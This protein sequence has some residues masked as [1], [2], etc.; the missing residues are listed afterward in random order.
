MRD[1]LRE[2]RVLSLMSFDFV[3]WAVALIAFAALRL[4][5]SVSSLDWLALVFLVGGCWLLQG[6][7]GWVLRLYHGRARVASLEEMLLLGWVAGTAGGITFAVNVLAYPDGLPRS[8]PLGGTFLALA[9]MGWGR[10]LWRRSKESALRVRSDHAEPALIFGAGDAGEQLVRS[11]LRDPQAAWAPVGLIDDDRWKQHLRID[12]VPVLGTRDS[13]AVAAEHTGARTLVIAVPSASAE[14]IRNV[15]GPARDAGLMVK[16]LPSLSE[17]MDRQVG[18][19]DIRD[20][21]VTDLLGRRQIETDLESIAGYLT[22]Q[23]VLVTGAGGSIG[24]EL[25]RQ[26]YRWGPAELIMLDRDESALH[27]AQLSI[28]GRALLDSNDVVLADIRDHMSISRVFQARRP[29]VVFHAAALKHLPMLE[30]Y[31][32]EAVKTNVW[33]TLAVLEAAQAAGVGKFINIST[34]K[35]AD[36]ISVLGYSKRIAE[37]LTAAIAAEA[38]GTYLSVRFGNVLGSRGSVLASFAAQIMAGGP[39]TVT[40]P[41]VTRFFMTVQEA[42]QLVIQAAAIGS[43]GEAL[44]LDMGDPVRIED[45][46]RQLIDQ[47]PVPIEIHYTGLRVGEKLH[48]D[49]F[50]VGEPDVRPAHPLISHVRVPPLDL[51]AVRDLD[52]WASSARLQ[53]E[54]AQ[55]GDTLIG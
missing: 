25:C 1:R 7:L 46:A 21:E 3:A 24:S 51:V 44:L 14:M 28:H 16:V 39:V 18:I 36:A 26:I 2:R 6:G 35:A 4:E 32:G 48:E 55:L 9:L 37:G 20:I 54:L 53:S 8:I 5:R 22:G 10:A 40:H 33:G 50:G 52:P 19:A 15:S 38:N 30:Q 13:V 34:D 12:G 45:V 43:D 17:L 47:A 23:C 49:L 11:M 42:V 27:A 29:Q 41:E 31:P